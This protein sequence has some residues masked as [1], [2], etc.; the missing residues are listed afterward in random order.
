M[1]RSKNNVLR[2]YLW[3]VESANRRMMLPRSRGLFTGTTAARAPTPSGVSRTECPCISRCQ[4][5][6]LRP[7]HQHRNGWGRPQLELLP[8]EDRGLGQGG[9]DVHDRGCL[10]Y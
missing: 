6:L 9:R 7:V 5:V 2:R 8:A 10:L 1:A 4:Q 3:M